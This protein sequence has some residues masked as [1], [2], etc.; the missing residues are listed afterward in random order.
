MSETY[1]EEH[2]HSRRNAMS[3]ELLLR[4]LQKHHGRPVYPMPA[5]VQPSLVDMY[6]DALP[7]KLARCKTVFSRVTVAVCHEFGIARADL[8]APPRAQVGAF[9][10]QVAM[11]LVASENPRGTEHSIGV[12]FN[13]D[14]TCVRLAKIKIPKLA[15]TNKSFGRRL[16]NLTIAIRS[17]A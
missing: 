1:D 4:R 11:A 6:R 15:S 8:L 5:V 17:A 14:K 13:R 3:T 7:G 2:H 9:P 12:L 10:R 16:R